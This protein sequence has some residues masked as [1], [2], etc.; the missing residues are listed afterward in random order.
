[1]K[2]ELGKK[3]K[4]EDGNIISVVSKSLHGNEKRK[5]CAVICSNVYNE[6]TCYPVDGNEMQIGS[7]FR[8]KIVECIGNCEKPIYRKVV[9]RKGQK[10]DYLVNYIRFKGYH[11]GIVHISE[12]EDALRLFSKEG[13]IIV[14]IK[15]SYDENLTIN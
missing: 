15:N 12:K 8:K 10:V 11:L 14:P 6:P 4:D 9:N 7:M 13:K 2:I 3:Y 1:M 5:V